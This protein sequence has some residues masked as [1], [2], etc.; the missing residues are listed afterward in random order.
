MLACLKNRLT[1]YDDEKQFVILSAFMTLF[2]AYSIPRCDYDPA[3]DHLEIGNLIGIKK[4][5]MNVRSATAVMMCLNGPSCERCKD[6]TSY[7]TNT[8]L[9]SKS[10]YDD[11]QNILNP[12]T[13]GYAR[14]RLLY[15]RRPLAISS[16]RT[17]LALTGASNG[18]VVCNSDD[19]LLND[20][21]GRS[22]DRNER[23]DLMPPDLRERID[24]DDCSSEGEE[25]VLQNGEATPGP[26]SHPSAMGARTE[27]PNGL[28]PP[29]NTK[30]HF[31]DG[32]EVGN[33]SKPFLPEF[34]SHETFEDDMSRLSR[35]VHALGEIS[36]ERE[37]TRLNPAAAP[38]RNARNNG[39]KLL[40]PSAPPFSAAPP[41]DATVVRSAWDRDVRLMRDVYATSPS[42]ANINMTKC[43]KPME[44]K[45]P[46]EMDRNPGAPQNVATWRQAR[47]E[48]VSS[49]VLRH[50]T[51]R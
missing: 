9:T 32:W 19:V 26:I 10:W 43:L 5:N 51:N 47:G 27:Q 45:T 29:A 36:K 13:A 18:S 41:Y 25:V 46:N 42:G 12:S 23:H 7:A 21:R 15:P 37:K 40:N 31:G 3:F 20:R 38:Y 34:A 2:E 8:D 50:G 22:C 16:W 48:R 44:F 24:S 30:W 11:Y 39:C 35:V 33:A 14:M 4:H 1:Q 6:I 49:R 17:T 28:A